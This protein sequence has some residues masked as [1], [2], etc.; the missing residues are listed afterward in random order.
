MKPPQ[1]CLKTQYLAQK[2]K[3]GLRKHVRAVG[4]CP[5]GGDYDDLCAFGYQFSECFWEGEIPWIIISESVL[6]IWGGLLSL[7]ICLESRHSKT[8]LQDSKFGPKREI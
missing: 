3:H 6:P 5:E 7:G 2:R 4:V 8:C 1:T